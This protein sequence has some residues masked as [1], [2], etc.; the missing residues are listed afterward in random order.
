MNALMKIQIILE[1]VWVH[2]I[3]KMIIDVFDFPEFHL[4]TLDIA[5]RNSMLFEIPPYY[6]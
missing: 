5:V 6:T 2:M 4:A 3:I 1:D